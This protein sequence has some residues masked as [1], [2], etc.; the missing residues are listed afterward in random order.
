VRQWEGG[1]FRETIKKPGEPHGRLRGAT[2]PRG[3]ARRKPS[4]W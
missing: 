3:P 2:D 4:R 1:L